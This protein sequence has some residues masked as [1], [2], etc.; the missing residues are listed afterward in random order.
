MSCAISPCVYPS[1][2]CST[3]TVLAPGGSAAMALS[4]AQLATALPDYSDQFSS[5]FDQLRSLLERFDIDQ[6]R[7]QQALSG[8][9]FGKLVEVLEGALRDRTGLDITVIARTAAELAKVVADPPWAPT[10]LGPTRLIV[11]FLKTAPKGRAGPLDLSSYGPETAVRKGKELY[12]DY[13]NGQGRSKVTNAVL[14]R[15][16]GVRCTARNW[17]TV[18]KMLALAGTT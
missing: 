6:D 9:D 18:E 15:L 12:V 2:S 16:L 3:N 4:A 11:V 8:F 17:N 7:I 14:E 13:V 1:T 5:L 10:A